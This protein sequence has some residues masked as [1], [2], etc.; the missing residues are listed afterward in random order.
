[1]QD[2]LT[3]LAIKYGTDK[4]GKHH[5]TPVYWD[6]FNKRRSDIKKI[7]E[8]GVGEGPSL[9][10]WRDFFPNAQV[11]GA[12]IDEKRI[13][14][15]DRIE[16]FKCDQAS[17][18]DLESLIKKTGS[19]I[20]IVIEDGSHIPFHQIFSCLTLMPLIK[21]DAVYIIEDVASPEILTQLEGYFCKMITV[22]KRYD[23]RLIIVKN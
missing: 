2:E 12:E 19:D 20:D 17:K 9:R 6:L 23:D 18:S 4:W 3:K 1:M 10:M 15:D 13:F 5:Y 8:I 11:Y 14:K 22:G 16:V 21:N 7:L